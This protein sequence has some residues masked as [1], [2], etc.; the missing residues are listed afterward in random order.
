MSLSFSKKICSINLLSVVTST[1]S[2]QVRRRG[3]FSF[4]YRLRIEKGL[5][6]QVE[7][8]NSYFSDVCSPIELGIPKS[9][10]NVQVC[11][12]YFWQVLCRFST[13]DHTTPLFPTFPRLT[14]CHSPNRSLKNELLSYAADYS[15]AKSPL[16][17]HSFLKPQITQVKH[18]DDYKARPWSREKRAV[19]V[20]APP[21]I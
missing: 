10:A 5:A 16:A 1:F 2:K 11:L 6:K 14:M 8:F 3:K 7:V 17:I 9:V 20:Q 4:T 12:L 21:Y 18:N 13:F 15:L 19:T